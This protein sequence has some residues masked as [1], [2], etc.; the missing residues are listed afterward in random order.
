[1]PAIFSQQV[2]PASISFLEFLRRHGNDP[3][4]ISKKEET[5][6][7]SGLTHLVWPSP[8]LSPSNVSES[9]CYF[10]QGSV[11]NMGRIRITLPQSPRLDK[12][13]ELVVEEQLLLAQRKGLQ[14]SE[15]RKQ[16]S[17]RLCKT[18]RLVKAKIA[19]KRAC[20]A[21]E[22]QRSPFYIYYVCM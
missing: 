16:V 18:R 5:Q 12:D 2:L 1:M 22:T 10:V 20:K 13:D 9:D 7:L 11:E 15:Q 19:E 3:I 4:I 21:G 14:H 6:I 8:P 17:I